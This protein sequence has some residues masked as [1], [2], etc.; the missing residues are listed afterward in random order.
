MDAITISDPSTASTPISTKSTIICSYTCTEK[1]NTNV[2]PPVTLSSE[3][4]LRC[5][6]SPN[7]KLN[8][9]PLL[10]DHN[11]TPPTYCKVRSWIDNHYKEVEQTIH[12][13]SR[14]RPLTT[15]KGIEPLPMLKPM[16]EKLPPIEKIPERKSSILCRYD[17]DKNQSNNIVSMRVMDRRK[18]TPRANGVSKLPLNSE[19]MGNVFE[20]NLKQRLSQSEHSEERDI[21]EF[22]AA[23]KIEFDTLDGSKIDLEG[24]SFT[25]RGTLNRLRDKNSECSSS[26][27]NFSTVSLNTGL[28]LKTPSVSDSKNDDVESIEGHRIVKQFP[29]SPDS[30]K[31]T[32]FCSYL[33]LV[34]MSSTGKKKSDCMQRRSTR[35]QHLMISK[36]KEEVSQ[37]VKRGRSQEKLFE[38]C[39][40]R[41]VSLILRLYKL[42][43]LPI[44][45]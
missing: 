18:S 25:H 40:D 41:K 35:V 30:K 14:V 26:K 7:K 12:F 1:K 9:T 13:R 44:T 20:N 27:S 2:S 11:M 32:E 45:I 36:Q 28:L 38:D 6:V 19:L 43:I 16:V 42:I 15:I 5:P 10:V 24:K 8:K 39:G 33:K 29:S 17:I 23:R 3:S 4:S 22:M 21:G 37:N 34:H 31:K